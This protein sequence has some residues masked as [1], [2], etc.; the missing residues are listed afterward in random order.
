MLAFEQINCLTR[1][2]DCKETG[3][4]MEDAQDMLEKP[5]SDDIVYASK[6]EANMASKVFF[7]T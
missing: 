2:Y 4:D 7:G 3:C 6:I 1:Q 5:S